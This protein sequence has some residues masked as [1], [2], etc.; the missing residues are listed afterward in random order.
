MKRN[1]RIYT[2]EDKKKNAEYYQ[3]NKEHIKKRN[4]D[5]KKNLNKSSVFPYEKNPNTKKN[6]KVLD[7]IKEIDKEIERLQNG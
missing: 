6:L 4:R 3:K 2:K 5:Y 7:R 1:K